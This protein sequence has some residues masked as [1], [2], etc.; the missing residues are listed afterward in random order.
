MDTLAMNHERAALERMHRARCIV[1]VVARSLGDG[2]DDPHE[3]EG[4]LLA[5]A[6]LIMQGMAA[7]DKPR[8]TDA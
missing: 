6:E 1:S 4:A 2:T 7:F 8:L 3:A 5:A